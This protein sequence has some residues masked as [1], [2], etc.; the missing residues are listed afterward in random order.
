MIRQCFLANTGI[1]FHRDSFK[2]IGLDVNKLY[3]V[4][5][6]RP[7]AL[8]ASASDGAEATASGH[9]AE[10]T[11][12]TLTDE[13]QASPTAAST[14]KSEEEEELTDALSPIY[15]E[16]KISKSWWILEVLPLRYSRQNRRDA[17]WKEY[18][19]YVIT[20]SCRVLPFN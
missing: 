5:V 12:G 3:P 6:A 15:D 20:S 13:V 18:W 7:P 14:F 10:P 16:L 9:A 19:A 11:D 4:V 17:S 8:K 2:D 1:Q